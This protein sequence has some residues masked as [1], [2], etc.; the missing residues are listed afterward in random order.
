MYFLGSN[1]FVE[2]SSARG[3]FV[4]SYGAGVVALLCDDTEA[5]DQI[6]EAVSHLLAQNSFCIH[7]ALA[8]IAESRNSWSDTRFHLLHINMLNAEVDIFSLNTP[9]VLYKNRAG[10]VD[11]FG[12][13]QTELSASS[14]L[15]GSISLSEFANLFFAL[16]PRTITVIKNHLPFLF[17]KKEITKTIAEFTSEEEALASEFLFINNEISSSK[18]ISKRDTV[19]ASLGAIIAYEEQLE[20]FMEEHFP[21][22]IFATT[23]TMLIFNELII[24]ALEHGTLGITRDEKQKVMSEGKYDEFIAQKESEADGKIHIEVDLYKNGVARFSIRDE[25]KGFDFAKYTSDDATVS[26]DR[27]HGRGVIMSRQTSIALLYGNGGRTVTFFMRFVKEDSSGDFLDGELLL[28][29]MTILYAEDDNFVRTHV[30]HILKRLAK[31]LLLAED[32]KEALELYSKYKPDIVITDVEMPFM[33]GLEL[34][35]AIRAENKDTPI[36]VTTAYNTEEF[37]TEAYESGVDKFLSKPISISTMRET[38]Y[39]FAR[40]AYAKEYMR[41]QLQ[42]EQ[43]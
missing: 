29:D 5:T 37:F 32:G 2:S 17:S 33:N 36:V 6:R 12:T 14:T 27:F 19:K 43:R 3:S 4:L 31:N 18:Q 23:N 39:G 25:G 8:T 1:F 21:E 26:L 42:K 7:R 28:K 24:N 15:V 38:L 16:H 13:V 20:L 22:D 41:K 40:S 10:Q 9:P 30:S 34:A 11:Q 35:R